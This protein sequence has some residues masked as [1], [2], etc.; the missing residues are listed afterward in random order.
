MKKIYIK[1]ITTIIFVNTIKR[2][3]IILLPFLWEQM[4][5]NLTFIFLISRHDDTMTRPLPES[6]NAIECRNDDD[7]YK[8]FYH[9]HFYEYHFPSIY[10]FNYFQLVDAM[11]RLELICLK[12]ISCRNEDHFYHKILRFT[13]INFMKTILL[14]FNIVIFFI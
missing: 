13:I 11:T 1:I 3:F 4:S 14:Q 12:V 9:Y 8:S 5:L 6:L 2:I 7:L 10:E